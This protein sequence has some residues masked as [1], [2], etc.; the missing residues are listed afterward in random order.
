GHSEHPQVSA[1]NLECCPPSAWNTVRH[2]AGT[3]SAISVESCPPWRGIRKLDAVLGAG[4]G[5]FAG[6]EVQWAT[7]RFTAHRARWVAAETWHPQQRGTWD[8]AGCWLL[9]LPYAD[10][11]ELEMDILRHMPH[12]E[13]LAPAVLRHSVVEKM[14]EGLLANGADSG[15]GS[16]FDTRGLDD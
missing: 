8:E 4:Y 12:V 13:V 10:P 5:I 11:R 9:E 1:I 3:P 15:A 2:H 7:L 6:H 16:G 14:R